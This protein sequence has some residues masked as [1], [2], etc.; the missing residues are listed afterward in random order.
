MIKCVVQKI[1]NS[2]EKLNLARSHMHLK[3]HTAT[4]EQ[5]SSLFF[6]WQIHEN[7]WKC[8]VI[9]LPN[10]LWEVQKSKLDAEGS[11][12]ESAK[13]LIKP[14]I[15]CTFAQNAKKTMF[16][17]FNDFPQKCPNRYLGPRGLPWS[18]RR[19]RREPLPLPIP[20]P[21][22]NTTT[23]GWPPNGNSVWKINENSHIL[24][25]W[26]QISVKI[27]QNQK[28]KNLREFPPIFHMFF[29][30]ME[31]QISHYTWPNCDKSWHSL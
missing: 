30:W 27:M 1:K 31:C 17:E 2:R 12:N 23:I 21:F 10:G 24:Q 14:V 18:A 25:D 6:C 19:P 20:L 26:C 15:Y 28:F 3:L 16:S 8:I 7:R 5:K 9:Y 29:K 22:T 13:T 11:Q 4:P